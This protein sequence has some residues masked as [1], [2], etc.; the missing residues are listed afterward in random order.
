[1]LTREIVYHLVFTKAV[2]TG[3]ILMMMV[4]YC[5]K[6]SEA[7]SKVIVENGSIVPDIIS[8][9]VS[10]DS[11]DPAIWVNQQDP[12]QSIIFGTDKNTDGAVYAFN[13]N[14]EIV[15]EKTITPLN[16]PN[17]IDIEYDFK[18]NDSTVVDV[19]AISER[20]KKQVRLFSVPDMK[21]LDGGGFPVFEDEENPE[22]LYPM[23]ISLYSSPLD[24]SL[25]VIVGRKDG[26]KENYLYQYKLVVKEDTVSLQ[27]SRKFGKY[28][29]A[30]E[31]EAIA[32]DDELGYVYYSD[33]TFGIRKYFAEPSKGSTEVACFGQGTFKEDNEGIAIAA[34]DGGEGYVI[35]SNQQAGTFNVFSRKEN[36]FIKELNLNTKETD[37]CEIVTVSLNNTFKN[38]IFVAMNNERNFYF[39]DVNKLSLQD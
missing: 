5:Q 6:E 16:R 1:M 28:S 3:L 23:G 13:L 17:N 36:Q 10:H 8:E 34:Y 7:T 20:G 14:G 2:I 15:E 31:I 22:Y 21:P 11:D 19:L 26:P 39:Y 38:G 27:L 30:K 9:K 12:S 33:E 35:V 32:V 4:T 18:I 24:Q 29:G 25:Y 37:G